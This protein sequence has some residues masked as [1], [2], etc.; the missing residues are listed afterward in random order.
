MPRLHRWRNFKL[1][2]LRSRADGDGLGSIHANGKS[3]ILCYGLL[4]YLKHGNIM[5]A[6]NRVQ[7]ATSAAPVADKR[8]VK[9]P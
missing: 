3:A 9:S 5:M 8:E 6:I 2:L 1:T 4:R 7:T